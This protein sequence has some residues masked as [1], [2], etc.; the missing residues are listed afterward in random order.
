MKKG[1]QVVCIDD[2]I[3]TSEDFHNKHF[4]NWIEEGVVYTVRAVTDTKMG[5]G[6]LFE[7]ITNKPVYIADYFGKAEPRFH[8]SRFRPLDVETEEVVEELEIELEND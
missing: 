5:P 6:L 7:E 2:M 4:Q 3:Y 8:A 1:D